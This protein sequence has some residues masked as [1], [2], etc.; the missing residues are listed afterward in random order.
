MIDRLVRMGIHV[1]G[2]LGLTPQ[3]V[4]RLGLRRQAVDAPAQQRL[5]NQASELRHRM[6]RP[7]ARA[8]S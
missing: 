1:M 2:H 6:L 8:C 7:G 5:M 3:A 4:H